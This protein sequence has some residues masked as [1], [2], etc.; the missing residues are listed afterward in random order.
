MNI[1]DGTC[2]PR[3]GLPPL[4]GRTEFLM[5]GRVDDGV[6]LWV[7]GWMELARKLEGLTARYSMV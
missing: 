1:P 3:L 5:N 7:N 6:V 2:S 4:D